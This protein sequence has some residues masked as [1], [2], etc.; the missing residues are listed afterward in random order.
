MG[1]KSHYPTAQERQ[2]LVS[3]ES[4]W[5]GDPRDGNL[6]LICQHDRNQWKR[7]SQ[8]HRRSIAETTMG[9][10]KG[11]FGGT[12]C[13]RRFE[14]QVS[15]LRVQCVVL[16]RMIHIAKPVTVWVDD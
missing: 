9:R 6:R 7:Q 1:C 11:T 12:V 4:S 3:W 16:N 5:T 2:G 15:E 8:H 13:S 14:N 10:F